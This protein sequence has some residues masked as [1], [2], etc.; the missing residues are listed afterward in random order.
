MLISAVKGTHKQMVR[1]PSC[2]GGTELKNM[3]EV[4]TLCVKPNFASRT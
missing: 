4:F 3:A 2:F 1:W